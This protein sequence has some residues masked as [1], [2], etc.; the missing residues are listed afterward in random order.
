MDIKKIAF[1]EDR[2]KSHIFLDDP[3]PFSELFKDKNIN[4]VDVYSIYSEDIGF[5]FSG[6]F[7][8]KNNDIRSLDGDTYNRGMLVYAYKFY[9]S[10]DKDI[11]GL[12]ILVGTD[13]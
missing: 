9:E 2:F 12:S 13:W 11:S 10:K 4:V 6:T 8:W 7:R 5:V 3:I 1:E